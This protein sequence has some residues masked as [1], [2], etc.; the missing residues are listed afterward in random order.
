V[1]NEAAWA[2][3]SAPGYCW[4]KNEEATFKETYG[5]LYNW[6]SVSTGK[7]C[8]AGWH[9]PSDEEWTVLTDYLGGEGKAGGKLKEKGTAYWV[10]PNAG[11]TNEYGFTAMPAGFRYYDGK[12]FDFGFSGY[13]WSSKEYSESRAFFRLLYYSDTNFFRFDNSKKIGFSVRC[14]K[15]R[16]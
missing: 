11:A 14:L 6:Y 5:A 9:V 3:L 16:P 2:G 13:W 8:P 7:L 4:Y 15:N 1:T 12:F 10:D